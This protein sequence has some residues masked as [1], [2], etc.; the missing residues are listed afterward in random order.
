MGT[1]SRPAIVTWSG[2]FDVKTQY[3]SRPSTQSILLTIAAAIFL[4]KVHAF[5]S[6]ARQVGWIGEGETRAVTI[7]HKVVPKAAA[8]TPTRDPLVL[9]AEDPIGVEEWV[10][11]T[12]DV[13]LTSRLSVSQVLFEQYE[14][15]T[16]TTVIGN[17]SRREPRLTE[18]VETEAKSAGLS[19]LVLALVFFGGCLGES[20]LQRR[21]RSLTAPSEKSR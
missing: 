13:V 6:S 21:S 14:V 10:N 5:F 1:A 15:G 17:P 8:E 11:T 19:A 20:Y 7:V 12:G 3:M 18:V 9:I 16:I 2:K 4:A